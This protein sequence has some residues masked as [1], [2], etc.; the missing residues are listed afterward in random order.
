MA[1]RL[2]DFNSATELQRQLLKS[3]I[4]LNLSLFN[5]VCIIET[6]RMYIATKIFNL[7]SKTS[8]PKSKIEF[9]QN[10]LVQSQFF[11]LLWLPYII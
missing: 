8:P 9:F 7:K 1:F 11:C 10:F 4:S 2:K 6:Y 3:I 5:S